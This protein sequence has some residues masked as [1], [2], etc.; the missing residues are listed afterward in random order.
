M[1]A[2]EHGLGLEP[3]GRVKAAECAPEAAPGRMP[4]AFTDLKWGVRPL[5]SVLT[6]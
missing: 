3:A 6:V 5:T 2:S 1:C 4:S